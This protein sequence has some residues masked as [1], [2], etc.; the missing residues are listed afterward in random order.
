[1]SLDPAEWRSDASS[2][3][4]DTILAPARSRRGRAVLP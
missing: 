3:L 2:D 4:L 1:M